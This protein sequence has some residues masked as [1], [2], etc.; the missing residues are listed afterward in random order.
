MPV[1]TNIYLDHTTATTTTI[2]THSGLEWSI[3]G[4]E[5]DRKFEFGYLP[6]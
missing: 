6:R 4:G 5:R 2:A 1:N 3:G